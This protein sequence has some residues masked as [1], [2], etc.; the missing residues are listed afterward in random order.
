MLERFEHAKSCLS[1]DAKAMTAMDKAA[2]LWTKDTCIDIYRDNT[3]NESIRVINGVGCWS[4][5]GKTGGRQNLSLGQGCETVGTAAHELGHALGFF[6]THSR[7]DRD[8]HITVVEKNIDEDWLNQFTLQT[9]ET[10]DNY[11]LPYDYGSLMQYAASSGTKEKKP[12]TFSMIPNQ[13]MKYIDTLG[14][15]IISFIDLYMMNV[16]YNCTDICPKVDWARCRNHGFPHPRD[17]SRCIC[18]GGYGGDYCDERPKGCGEILEAEEE[19]KIF[20]DRIGSNSKGMAPRYEFDF[21][22]YWIQAPPG[23]KIRVTLVDFEPEKAMAVEG[24]T[25]GG[26]EFKWQADQRLTGSRH[27]S[28]EYVGYEFTSSSNLMPGAK[29]ST[30]SMRAHIARTVKSVFEKAAKLWAKDTCLDI[31]QDNAAAESI[32]VFKEEGCWSYVGKTRGKQ[33]L[34]LGHG[35]ES[36]GTAAHE[37]GHAL[38]FFHTHS[39]HDRNNY[40]DVLKNNIKED[41]WDQFTLES[42]ETNDNYDLPYDYGSLMQ[43]GATS[44]SKDK[45][46]KLLSMIPLDNEYTETLGSPFISFIDLLMMNRHY[47]CT[48]NCPT[49][50]SAKCENDGFPHPRNCSECICP[51]GY[52]GPLCKDRPEGCGEI[53]NA[54][55]FPVEWTGVIGN[56]SAGVNPRED[57]DMCY[58]WIT[59]P[60]GKKVVVELM[61]F[62]PQGIAVDGCTYGGV[63]FKWHW[64][65]RRTGSRYCSTE[66]ANTKLIST[67]NIMP[68]IMYNRIYES[69]IK[70][71]YYYI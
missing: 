48:G 53:L 21:C 59:A 70:I 18:P 47:N 36:I 8:Q 13:D 34:S 38:G 28:K 60:V 71:K 64:D 22:H 55:E 65:R 61:S 23:K 26:V 41:W 5:A 39:R 68:V 40:I 11:G 35:C 19:P 51:G 46:K 15:H 9:K 3:A 10:N 56:K 33:N 49:A 6:H 52:G 30:S 67:S 29:C 25:Y 54:T 1:P 16:H 7:H 32:R 69:T 20:E 17:C 14:S 2:K 66:D 27:C 50:T 57:F 45:Q 37:L 31:Y 63:E 62:K 43:Y 58:Y 42:K 4:Y 24:C 12:T 44:A